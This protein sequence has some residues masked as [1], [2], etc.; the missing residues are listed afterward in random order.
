VKDVENVDPLDWIADSA[1]KN[2]VASM[3][4]MTHAALLVSRDERKA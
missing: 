1:V 2:L 3:H 4:A